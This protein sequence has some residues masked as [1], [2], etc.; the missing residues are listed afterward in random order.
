MAEVEGKEVK[1]VAE[2]TAS[3][4]EKEVDKPATEDASRRR[5]RQIS[6]PAAI[7]LFEDEKGAIRYGGVDRKGDWIKDTVSEGT[8]KTR[9][10]AKQAAKAEHPDLRIR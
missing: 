5:S 6:K 2:E 7:Y 4:D 10:L 9:Q 3:T 8:Y 1:D